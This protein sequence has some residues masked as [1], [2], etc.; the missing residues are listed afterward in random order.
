[1]KIPQLIPLVLSAIFGFVLGNVYGQLYKDQHILIATILGGFLA[2]AGSM[3]TLYLGSRAKH[4]KPK[5]TDSETLSLLPTQLDSVFLFN[6]LHNISALTSISP[7]KASR[8]V[9]QLATLI[10]AMG[11]MN[12]SNTTLLNE[13]FRV[14]ELYL[15]I[16]QARF[17]QRLK[18]RKS[19]DALC[20]ELQV[21]CF[22]LLPLVENCIRHGIEVFDKDVEVIINATCTND[23]ARID[24]SD[25]GRG[26][27]TNDIDSLIS[28]TSGIGKV[29]ENLE[30]F[31]GSN[32]NLSVEALAPSGTRVSIVFPI[33][34]NYE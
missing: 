18:I 13:E 2:V 5:K 8:T 32:A 29:K 25:T 19:I 20:L 17:G 16:E 26:I 23:K 24:V 28:P 15:Q 7:E 11:E 9:E 3:I 27:E 4:V 6:T 14:A 34:N 31:F 10:R 21:P 33:L 30:V 22:L 1:M 12:T